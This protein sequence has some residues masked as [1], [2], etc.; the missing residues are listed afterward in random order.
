M[1]IELRT[2]D[3]RLRGAKAVDPAPIVASALHAATA[4]V[5]NADF[6]KTRARSGVDVFL[7]D[8]RNVARRK[9]VQID[10]R[11]DRHVMNHGYFSAF[12]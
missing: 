5:N 6:A 2:S 12:G 11:L 1:F 10:L 3:D 8:R 9:G 7:D 4:S